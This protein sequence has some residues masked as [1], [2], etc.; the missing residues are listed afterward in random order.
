VERTNLKA[1]EAKRLLQHLHG[2]PKWVTRA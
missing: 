2:W 1:E